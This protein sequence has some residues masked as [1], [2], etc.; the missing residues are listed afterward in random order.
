MCKSCV[1]C[2]DKMT[3]LLSQLQLFSTVLAKIK[4]TNNLEI[5][6]RVNETFLEL[7]SAYGEIPKEILKHNKIN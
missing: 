4:E 1:W 3:D 2:A 6:D 5:I 7:I